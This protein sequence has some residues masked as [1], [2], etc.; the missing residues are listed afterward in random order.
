MKHDEVG[1][2][3]IKR[4]LTTSHVSNFFSSLLITYLSLS[5]DSAS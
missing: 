2:I 1:F 4:E 5:G 3:D